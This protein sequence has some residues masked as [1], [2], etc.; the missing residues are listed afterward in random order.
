MKPPK[1]ELIPE[2]HGIVRIHVQPHYQLGVVDLKAGTILEIFTP[3]IKVQ[4]ANKWGKELS[5]TFGVKYFR[6][7]KKVI[8]PQ[9]QRQMKEQRR[10]EWATL[11]EKRWH[12]WQQQY[13]SEALAI[14][15]G[16]RT[17]NSWIKELGTIQPSYDTI[18]GTPYFYKEYP[19]GRDRACVVFAY[20][21]KEK[22]LKDNQ[23]NITETKKVRRENKRWLYEYQLHIKGEEFNFHGYFEPPSISDEQGIS[24]PQFKSG[25][26]LTEQEK[27][28]IKKICNIDGAR[29]FTQMIGWKY[30]SKRGF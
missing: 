17:M 14:A 3:N 2:E 1:T 6:N 19:D 15:H 30:L 24:P 21:I 16:I 4:T 5:T 23:E 18:H 11:Q 8:N 26:L 7:T 29:A 20:D 10:K 12:Q 25:K 9:I 28:T 22:W 27:E 13:P